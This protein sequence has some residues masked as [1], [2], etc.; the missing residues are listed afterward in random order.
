M[1]KTIF[2][3]PE[4]LMENV[5]GVTS[6]LRK[7]IIERGGNPERKS[8]GIWFLPKTERISL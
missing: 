1:N 2:L 7:K 3:N 5:S 4:E 6:W 8:L